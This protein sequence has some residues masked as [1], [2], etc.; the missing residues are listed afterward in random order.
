MLHLAARQADREQVFYTAT[1]SV[2]GTIAMV[3]I[4]VAL[5]AFGNFSVLAAASRQVFAF[6]RDQGLPFSNTLRKI[7][8]IGTP[9]PAIAIVVSLLITVI[10]SLINLGSVAAFN[11]IVGLLSGSGG[12]SYSIS[13]GCVLWRRLFGKPLPKSPFTL[14]RF[15]S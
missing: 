10:L 4:I 5:S 8:V 2:G 12:V 14:G 9:I 3:S 11:S 15:V 13:I 6:A 7:T 1:G